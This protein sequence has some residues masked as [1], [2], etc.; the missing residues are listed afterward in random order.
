MSIFPEYNLQP[1]NLLVDYRPG[2]NA[3][4]DWMDNGTMRFVE[5]N[6]TTGE[7]VLGSLT[8]LVINITTLLGNAMVA[9]ACARTLLST[10]VYS[11]FPSCSSVLRA[12]PQSYCPCSRIGP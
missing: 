8:F 6:R 4:A 5:T 3:S 10:H 7:L 9:M 12:R 11:T 1:P 2:D